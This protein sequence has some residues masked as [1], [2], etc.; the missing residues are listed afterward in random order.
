MHERAHSARRQLLDPHDAVARGTTSPSLVLKEGPEDQRSHLLRGTP[1]SALALIHECAL[2]LPEQTGALT[3]EN[4]GLRALELV[5]RQRYGKS[6][7]P[8]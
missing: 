7:T 5:L 4:C 2:C 8:H 3:P 6:T 1:G